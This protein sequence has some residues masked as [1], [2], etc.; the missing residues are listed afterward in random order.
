MG[1]VLPIFSCSYSVFLLYSSQYSMYKRRKTTAAATTKR[2]RKRREKRKKERK[3]KKY[4]CSDI[5]SLGRPF[6]HVSPFRL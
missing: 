2:N 3:R 4:L 6:Y 1:G 5:A